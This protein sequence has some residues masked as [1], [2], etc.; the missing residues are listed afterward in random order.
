MRTSRRIVV[1][2]MA[3][4]ASEA[5]RFVIA[6]VMLPFLLGKFGREGYGLLVLLGVIVGLT[7]VMDLGVRGALGRHL[8]EQVAKKDTRRFNELASTALVLY[9]VIASVFAAICLALAPLLARVF[10]VSDELMPQAVFLIRWYGS[11]SVMLSFIAPVFA[12][13]IIANNRF[14][15]ANYLDIGVAIL[16]GLVIFAVVGLTDAGLYG[17]AGVSLAGQVILLL[18]RGFTARRI[19]PSLDIRLAH[20]RRDALRPLFSLGGYLFVFNMTHLL[21]VRA[22]PIVLTWF[23]GLAGVSLYNPGGSLPARS[24]RLVKTLSRQ[25]HP[26]ATAYH[27]TGKTQQLQAVLIR[28]T[29]YTLLMGIPVCVILGIFAMPIMRL[30]LERVLGADYRIPALVMTGWAVVDLFTYAAGSQ[31]SVLLGMNRLKF[32]V[33]T[34]VPAGIVNILV[35]IILVGYT[36]LGIPGIMVATVIIAAIRR[37]II[38]VYT[39]RVCGMSARRYLMESYLRP[40]LVLALVAAVGLALR[41]GVAPSSLIA[42][43]ACVAGVGCLWVPLCWWVGFNPADRESFRGLLRRGVGPTGPAAP[44]PAPV[45]P[46][47]GGEQAAAETLEHEVADE[48]RE[49]E[50][51]I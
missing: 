7:T 14:D 22:D 30:W 25:L 4:W 15:L 26:L 10:K 3:G 18:L 9:L 5:V 32:L 34:S 33:W 23:F 6:L 43:A 49:S 19:W 27:V 39:A 48:I 28:G 20:F 40:I 16:S 1:N 24:R 46:A 37:P 11:I 50:E 41:I 38:T 44:G 13:T 17:W 12:A 47:G 45:S 31:W 29:R 2:A 36:S 21:S 42:L 51:I 35:S 8:A